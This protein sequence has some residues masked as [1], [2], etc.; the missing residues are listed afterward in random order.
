M[1]L[2][3]AIPLDIAVLFGCAIPTGSG[4]I[5]NTIKPKPGSSIAIFG[6]GGIGLSALMATKL[7]NLRTIVAIDINNEKLKLAE[8]FGAT[9][10]INAKDANPLIE[11]RKITNGLGI[12]Y[13]VESSGIAKTIE[14]AF[15][16][17]KRNG[18]LCVFASHP[19]FGEKICLEPYELIC[20]KNIKG[21]WG[22]DSKPDLDIPKF[23]ELYKTGKLPL[24]KFFSKVYKLEEINEALDDLENHRVA[25]PLIIIDPNIE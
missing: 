2:P 21:S 1:P 22:G 18:G 8:E 20:G 5:T 14:L 23:A 6:L 9:H 17:V 15:D 3:K 10:I 12:D 11:I 16:S 24:E 13:S 7:Y 4:I 19:Q 25:R